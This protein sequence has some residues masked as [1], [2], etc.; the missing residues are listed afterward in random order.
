MTTRQ[1]RIN[2]LIKHEIGNIIQKEIADPRVGFVTVTDVEVTRDLAHARVFVSVL[3]DQ[4]TVDAAMEGLK[5]AQGFLRT[6]LSRRA[7]L[8]AVPAISFLLDESAAEGE[9]IERLLT[10]VKREKPGILVTALENATKLVQSAHSFFIVSHVK[11]DGDS[12]GSMLALARMLSR[13]GRRVVVACEDPTPTVYRFLAGADKIVTKPEE[14][15]FDLAVVLDCENLG[16]VGNLRGLVDRARSVLNLDHHP[17]NQK[18][19]EA[20]VLDPA[21]GATGELVYELAQHLGIIID[22]EEA[23]A[24]RPIPLRQHAAQDV[25]DCGQL[26]APGRGSGSHLALCL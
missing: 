26:G 4:Q 7:Y 21:A 14:E 25:G 1:E 6:E 2:S 20:T 5:Q 24:H 17:E 12:I 18:F 23:E 22:E 11:P 8:R 9:R 15:I 10:E 16:R 19:G 13:T 3:G